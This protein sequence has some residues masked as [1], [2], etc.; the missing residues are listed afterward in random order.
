MAKTINTMPSEHHILQVHYTSA[1]ICGII[2]FSLYTK[3][4]IK[5]SKDQK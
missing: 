1:C 3:Y 2:M 5:R 4:A